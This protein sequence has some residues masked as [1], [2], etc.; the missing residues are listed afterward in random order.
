MLT[1]KIIKRFNR[2]AD[3]YFTRLLLKNVKPVDIYNSEYIFIFHQVK[4]KFNGK[5]YILVSHELSKLGIPSC[6]KF[7]NDLVSSYYPRFNIDGEQISNSF[8]SKKRFIIESSH[9]EQLFFKWEVDLENEKME[10][11]GINF[12][13][14]IRNTLRTIQKRYNVIFRDEDNRPFYNELIQSCDLMLKYFLLLKDYSLKNG[15][16]IR[17]VGFESNYVPNGVLKMLCEQSA[18]NR[19]IE[20]IELRRGYM[21]YFGQHH[22]RASYIYLSNLTSTKTAGGLS[23]SKEELAGF[24]EKSYDL[25]KLLKP[26]SKVLAKDMDY[27]PSDRQKKIIKMMED[28]KGRGRMVF[29]LFPHVF[30]DT[31]VDDKSQV[32]NDMCEWIKETIKYFDGKGDLLLIKPHP[33]EFVKDQPKRTPTETLASFL[34]DI[35]L[36]NNIIILERDLFTIKDLSAFITCGL[37]WRSS[38]GMELTFL[39]IPCIIAG[40]PPYG[41]LDLIYAKDKENYFHMIEHADTLQVTDK[42]KIEVATYLYLLENKHIHVSCIAYDHELRE[43]YWDR[44]ALR[45]YLKNGNKEFES[46]VENMLA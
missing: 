4:S 37:V 18:Y 10:A 32:F 43:F 38:V 8:T 15:K 44:K 9:G 42:Q 21:S 7:K 30:Y 13:P 11:E 25:D 12:F 45:K 14:I 34:S 2:L 29:V 23:V 22:Q 35:E 31:P 39:G 26:V 41:S 36:S 17:L 24:D 1:R 5:L 16:K 40:I 3:Y 33:A 20:F 27:K 28:Y 46:V 19:D 6:F